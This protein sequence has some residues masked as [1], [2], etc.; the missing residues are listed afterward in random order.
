VTIFNYCVEKEIKA[1]NRMKEPDSI[2][3]KKE[4]IIETY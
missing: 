1:S 3:E 2:L 4:K